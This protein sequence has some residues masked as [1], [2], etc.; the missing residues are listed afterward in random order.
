MQTKLDI[1]RQVAEK[2][3]VDF[4]LVQNILDIERSRLQSGPVVEKYRQENLKNY[5]MKWIQDHQ[6]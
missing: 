5:L 2:A 4:D 6:V 3:G 1:L